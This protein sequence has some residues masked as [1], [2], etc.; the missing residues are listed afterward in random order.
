MSRTF[1][2]M[3][4][5]LLSWQSFDKDHGAPVSGRTL[6]LP[7]KHPVCMIYHSWL[8]TLTNHCTVCPPQLNPLPPLTEH[9]DQWP[10]S[11]ASALL[12]WILCHH[13]LS[14]L[15]SDQSVRTLPSSPESCATIGWAHW[16]VTNQFGLCPPHLNLVPQSAELSTNHC[17]LTP[18]S[19]PL[20]SC[21][22]I[23][24]A[25]WPLT[26]P[27]VLPTWILFHHCWAHWPI[28]AAFAPHWILCHNWLS[29]LTNHSTLCPPT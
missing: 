24:L 26:P 6:M 25:L 12:T 28:N 9:A 1:T 3:Y 15:T 7:H 2:R 20:E 14:T 21:A 27:Y 4:L 18:Q 29:A 13:W 5:Q 10:I 17:T 16:P 19:S 22:T 8:R 23:A 11:T